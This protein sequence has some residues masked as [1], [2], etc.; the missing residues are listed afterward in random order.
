MKNNSDTI[1]VKCNLIADTIHLPTFF[2]APDGKVL[3]EN[4][5]NQILNPLYENQKDKFFNPLDFQSSK[6]FEFPVIKKS[7]FSEK[8]I[9]ISVYMNK[10]FEGTVIIGPIL[11][12]ALTEERINGIIND[13]KAFFYREK[14]HNYYKSLRIIQS[15]EIRNISVLLFYL[16]NERLISADSVVSENAELTNKTNEIMSLAVSKKL[17]SQTFSQDRLFEKKI[18]Y[19]VK[20][21]KLE[22]LKKINILKEEEVASI[23]SKSSYL[24][25][26]KNHVITL[27]T[28]IS[29]TSMEGGLHEDVA[30]SLHDKFI[31]ELEE[32]TRL[33]EV[34][35][36]A[37][38]VIYTYTERVQ[39]VKNERYSKTITRCKNYIF[40]NIYGE[41]NHEGIANAVELSPK[42]L[43]VLF[44]KEV[45][46]TV[47]EYIQQIKIEEA[48]K[49]LA[50]SK[51]PI[52]EICSLLNYNDQS[53]F[54]KVF[55]KATDTTPKQFRERQHLM[56]KK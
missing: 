34:R 42:Y 36:L 32:L 53:Y 31:Q 50:Y 29:R 51:L 40:T 25:S 6:E 41:I 30:F 2:V 9:I 13:S 3:Y 56:K 24:R 1:K 35:R 17:Q 15:E 7:V 48:K 5:K 10:K 4:L 39:E 11:S 14:V 55:K 16:F 27:I 49:L 8:Y 52:S 22:E 18:L 38:E 46:L 12:F 28:L 54:T 47:S 19:I 45:G 20:E 33:D 43:S 44:K 37:K 23:L 21:G 26:I